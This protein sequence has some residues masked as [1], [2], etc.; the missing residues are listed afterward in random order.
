M[1][2]IFDLSALV[3]LVAD[4]LILSLQFAQFVTAGHVCVFD[5]HIQAYVEVL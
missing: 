3:H 1:Y 4:T 5:V 2:I